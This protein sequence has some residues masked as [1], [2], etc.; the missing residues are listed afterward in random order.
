VKVIKALEIEEIPNPHDISV[1]A[2]HKSNQAQFEHLLLNPG[3]ALKMHVSYTYVY[4]YV[5]EGEG[6]VEAGD[7][8]REITADTL[9]EISP[10][11][12]HRL[13]NRGDSVF[14]VLNVKAP[15]A[16]KPTHLV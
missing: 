15:R 9:V 10:E 1:R 8:S 13:I 6:I 7:E 4:L 2:L 3:D 11:V 12:P 5:L 14:R 16:K